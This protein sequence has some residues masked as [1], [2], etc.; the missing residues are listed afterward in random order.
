MR[1][2]NTSLSARRSPKIETPADIR[3]CQKHGLSAANDD[4][5]ILAVDHPERR[6]IFY[7]NDREVVPG[8]IAGTYDHPVIGQ[9]LQGRYGG[10]I[11]DMQLS[12]GTDDGAMSRTAREGGDRSGQK[13]RQNPLAYY[14]SSLFFL[15]CL[16]DILGLQ[17]ADRPTG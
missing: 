11:K 1:G 6:N 8:D 9:G 14:L 7:I 2:M 5:A 13:H 3:P 4:E 16:Q 12:H 15:C 10:G 17:P